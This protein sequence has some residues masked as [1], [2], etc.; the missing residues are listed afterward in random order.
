MLWQV[1]LLNFGL[2]HLVQCKYERVVLQDDFVVLDNFSL[3]TN[4]QSISPSLSLYSAP[5]YDLSAFRPKPTPS[6]IKVRTLQRKFCELMPPG[7]RW[8][9][10]C[11]APS[12]MQLFMILQNNDPLFHHGDPYEVASAFNGI[13]M[14]PIGLIRSRGA[15]ARYDAGSDGQRCEHIGFNL[16]LRDTMM[17]N[18]KWVMHLK[19]NKPGGPSGFHTVTKVFAAMSKRQNVTTVISAVNMISLFVFV[20][21]VWVISL[22][23]KE[24]VIPSMID[25]FVGL[26]NRSETS[27]LY[28]YWLDFT[29]RGGS[30]SLSHH[31]SL[32]L[33]VMS[34]EEGKKLLS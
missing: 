27:F 28:G 23:M 21:S 29:G 22:T 1:R 6:N 12:P 32:Q 13:T 17:V 7:D 11:D 8:R 24:R 15:A 9:N 18:P 14:Y 16:S 10:M 2:E 26:R 33:R 20:L 4:C 31:Q 34:D 3:V 19:P 30:L 5:P 25:F